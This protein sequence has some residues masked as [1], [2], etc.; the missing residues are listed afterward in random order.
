MAGVLSKAKSRLLL[1]LGLS[2]PESCGKDVSHQHGMTEV[3][4]WNGIYI[5]TLSAVLRC[6]D[7][8]NT[9]HLH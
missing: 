3:R 1:H 9:L 4:K 5:G 7:L 6:L 8:R 2:P